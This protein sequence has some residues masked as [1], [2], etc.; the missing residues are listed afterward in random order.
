[1]TIKQKIGLAIA[2]IALIPIA[3]FSNHLEEETKDIW[4]KARAESISW[5]YN[6]VAEEGGKCELDYKYDH[7][8]EIINLEVIHIPAELLNN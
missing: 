5:C 6:L 8:G 3:I 2:I 4:K 7:N 1:M